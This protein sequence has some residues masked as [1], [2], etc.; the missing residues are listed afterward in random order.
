MKKYS[1]I[2]LFLMVAA[3][4]LSACKVATITPPVEEPTAIVEETE[5]PAMW[6][7]SQLKTW[8]LNRRLI[9]P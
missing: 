4:T 7:L 6:S 8:L 5:D 3:L 1:K 9:S 2:V